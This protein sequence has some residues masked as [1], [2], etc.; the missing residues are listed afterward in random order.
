MKRSRESGM[1]LL[2]VLWTLLLV[3]IV[4]ASVSSQARKQGMLSR[5][6][7][8]LAQT[9]AAAE[10]GVIRAIVAMLDLRPEAAWRAD[11]Q[12]HR[13][14]LDQISVEIRIVDEAGKVD[15]NAAPPEMV[16][17]LLRI[18]GASSDTAS[19]IA[20]GISD[21]RRG[22]V[23][24]RPKG[25]E[26]TSELLAIP[27]M[28]PALYERAA[29]FLTVLTR[30]TGIDPSVTAPE[31]LAALAGN[32][33]SL[34]AIVNASRAAAPGAP[35]PALPP[36]GYL[37]QSQHSVFTIQVV[38]STGETRFGRQATIRLTHN[39]ELPFLVHSWSR[40]TVPAGTVL[41]QQ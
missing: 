38:A 15:I 22:A 1:A 17:T 11:G 2:V 21:L 16:A 12:V 26:T 32:D 36:N 37:S 29:P 20:A 28:T 39:A 8:L 10:A 25:F 4:G 35:G 24:G 6:G 33:P 5:N 34:A 9:E 19:S 18:C 40:M 3:G 30:A 14:V 7:A 23:T 41:A 31:L 13:F 27:G